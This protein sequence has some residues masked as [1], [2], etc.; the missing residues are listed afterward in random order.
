MAN[1]LELLGKRAESDPFFLACSLKNFAASEQ[2]DDAALAKKLECTMETLTMLRLCRAPHADGFKDDIDKIAARF[3]VNR[4][5]LAQAARR[6]QV[7]V[8]VR[9]NAPSDAGMLLAA[10]DDDK[11]EPENR[12]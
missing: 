9:R 8:Q 10:R 2:L 1:E 7:L 6:G 4:D 3:E 12:P 11:D 5:A